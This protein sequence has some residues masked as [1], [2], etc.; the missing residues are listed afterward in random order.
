MDVFDD[1]NLDDSVDTTPQF[2]VPALQ[3]HPSSPVAEPLGENPMSCALIGRP[4]SGKTTLLGAICQA[5]TQP[6]THTTDFRMKL[7]PGEDGARLLQQAHGTMTRPD[8][9]LPATA[10]L[11]P[12]TFGLRVSRNRGNWRPEWSEEVRM[13]VYDGPGG[14]LFPQMDERA[15][16]DSSLML[17]VATEADTVILCIDT[18]RL[19]IGDLVG[20]LPTLLGRLAAGTQCIRSASTWRQRVGMRLR[21]MVQVPDP[22]R[23]AEVERWLCVKRF[24]VLLTKVDDLVAS[25][26]HHQRFPRSPLEIAASIDPIRQACEL[27]GESFLYQ[28]Y[29][30]LRPSA[31]LAVGVTSSWGFAANNGLPFKQEKCHPRVADWQ[32]LGVR[33]AVIFAVTGQSTG[34]VCEVEEG[35]LTA[36]R[37]YCAT[38][39]PT[40]MRR[41]RT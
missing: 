38:P 19:D 3:P 36:R 33:D 4:R 30:A 13:T 27:L 35:S 41:R 11:Q 10:T 20:R 15:R 14:A 7:L 37:R 23:G 22:R 16:V 1:L 39:L 26:C 21:S 9:M 8:A 29:G 31:H 2:K 25:V 34:L 40:S 17:R 5:C 32:P 18:T 24:L 6:P 12:Y 28:I